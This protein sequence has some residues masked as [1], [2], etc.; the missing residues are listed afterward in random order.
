MTVQNGSTYEHVIGST[1]RFQLR[2]MSGS[3]DLRAVDGET[4]RVTEKSGKSIAEVFQVDA[5]EGRLTLTSPDRGG[6][7]LVV[8]GIGRRSSLDL[9]VEVPRQANVSIESASADVTIVGLVARTAV[10][11]AS[12]D[13]EMRAM[14][15]KLELD[16]VSGEVSVDADAP[17]D[18]R[19]RTISGDLAI[20]AP[21]IRQA[22][23]E[24]TSGDVR[25]DALLTGDGPFEIQTVS[26]DATI[27]G[28]AGL[29][30]EARTVTG[31]LRSDLPHRFDKSPGRKQLVIGDGATTVGFRSVSGD[32]RVVAPRDGSAT[33]FSSIL[34]A[35]AAPMPPTPPVPPVA[36]S[37]P[38]G[39]G[40]AERHEAGH[41]VA[42]LDILHALERGELSV[43]TA[44]KRLADIE[45]A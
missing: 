13:V 26:G 15:G 31:D 6:I 7:D 22:A 41:E 40:T 1:G 33:S 14:G 12:G 20:H 36:P 9:E 17:I 10:R 3:I 24:T 32:L 44:M 19:A 43:E 45:E 37:A 38:A 35:P 28:R 16:A 29:R 4:V 39:N 42:R 23:V 5:G 25:L 11:T 8:F 21:Q 2:Q 18:L 27:V 30:I 34:A